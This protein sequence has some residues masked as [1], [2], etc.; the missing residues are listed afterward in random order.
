LIDYD[1]VERKNLNRI[2]NTSMADAAAERL[3]VD[4][5][6]TAITAYRGEVV[7]IPLPKSRDTRA[8]VIAASQGDVIFGCVDTLDARYMADLIASAFLIPLIDVGVAIP[9]RASGGIVAIA[10]AVGRV[11]YVQ[12]GGA[13]LG[14][15]KVYTPET[16]RAEYL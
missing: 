13:T 3:K 2:L 11:D 9:V 10:D 4:A 14:D 12:P 7:A 8:A 16:L 15:R 5:C 6:S 1:R